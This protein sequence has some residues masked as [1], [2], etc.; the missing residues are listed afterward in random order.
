MPALLEKFGVYLYVGAV[1]I[2][3]GADAFYNLM[4]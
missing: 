3:V 1:I 2:G 4:Q